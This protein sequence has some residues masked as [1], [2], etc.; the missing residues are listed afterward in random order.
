MTVNH[1][2]KNS[3][4][5]GSHTHGWGA[6]KKHRGAGNRGG[7][8]KSGSG[9]RADSNKPSYWADPEYFGKHGFVNKGATPKIN[10]INLAQIEE[11]LNLFIQKKLAAH[12][13]GG[14]RI[15]LK[16]IGFNKLL[17]KGKTSRK[18]FITCDYASSKAIEAV[19]AAGGKISLPKKEELNN[20]H[21]GNT[22]KS[23]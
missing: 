4:Q 13:A 16:D 2:R 1:R 5:R 9:K 19:E 12:E 22:A 7:S 6:M 23:S 17:G 10:P 21:E 8:G 14:F 11:K 15:N 18:L 20:G 3:R